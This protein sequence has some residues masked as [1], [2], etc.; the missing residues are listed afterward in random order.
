VTP[1]EA[2]AL[3]REAQEW[4]IAQPF[5]A[6]RVAAPRER[7]GGAGDSDRAHG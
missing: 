4:S 7:I 2:R 5:F 3:E 1:A 6:E